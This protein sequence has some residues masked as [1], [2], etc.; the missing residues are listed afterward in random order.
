MVDYDV[1]IAGGG[2][3]GTITAQ[4]ISYYSNQI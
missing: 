4:S 2:L 3:A 1:I